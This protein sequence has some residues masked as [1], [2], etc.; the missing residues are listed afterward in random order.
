MRDL[1]KWLR[2]LTW[3]LA[4]V[5]LLV[6]GNQL[7]FT[8]LPILLARPGTA[9]LSVW[10]VLNT[11]IVLILAWRWYLLA[12]PLAPGT[13]WLSWLLVRQAGQVVSFVTPGPQF[14]GE[15]LQVFWLWKV[16]RMPGHAALLA[17]CLDRFYELWVNFAVLILALLLLVFVAAGVTDHWLPVLMTVLLFIILLSLAGWGLIR[18]PQLFGQLLDKLAVRWQQVPKLAGLDGYWSRLHADLLGL[19]RHHKPALA[20]ALVASVLG[21]IGMGL[22]IWLLL[23]FFAVD[24]DIRNFLV[25]L[26]AIRLAFLL[27]LPGGIGTLEAAVF[28]ACQMQG[29]PTDTAMGLIVMI[30][31]RDAVVMGVGLLCLRR[32]NLRATN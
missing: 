2:V 13:T 6:V 22:E 10:V 7:P 29:M 8:D 12:R 26:V 32:L 3:T 11:L 15:P 28:W 24:P 18:Y 21:W 1:H 25:L 16:Y 27:P 20:G 5:L 9:G 31:L 17:V 30:R 14:G 23:R 19:V 4:L